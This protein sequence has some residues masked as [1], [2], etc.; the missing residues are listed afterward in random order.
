[1]VVPGTLRSLVVSRNRRLTH[2]LG[3]QEISRLVLTP[4]ARG[5]DSAVDTILSLLVAALAL[6]GL[7]L[8]LAWLLPSPHGSPWAYRIAV[9][10]L[11]AIVTAAALALLLRSGG[12][13]LQPV[14]L[15]AVGVVAWTAAWVVARDRWKVNEWRAAVVPLVAMTGAP[16]IVWMISLAGYGL[17]LPNRDFKNHAYWVAQVSFERS[18]DPTLVLRATPLS[19]PETDKFY[20]L[21]LHTLLGWA[22]PTSDWNTLGVTAG[23]AIICTAVSLP[24]AGVVL[25]RMWVPESQPLWIL[26][27]FA[28]AFFPGM[29]GAFGIGS[30]TI[31]VA[32]ALYSAGL[33]SLWMWLKSPGVGQTVALA[34]TGAGLLLLHI[35]EAWGLLLLAL[36]ALPLVGMERISKLSVRTWAVLGITAA[37]SVIVALATL[38]PILAR[39]TDGFTD[40]QPNDQSVPLAVLRAYSAQ[41]G[42]NIWLGM[43]WMVSTLIGLAAAYRRRLSML[44]ALAL[45]VPMALAVFA[46]T[47][48]VP[49]VLYTMTAPW[50]GSTSRVYLMA[51]PPIALLGCFGLV[52][53]RQ[54]FSERLRGW[55]NQRDAGAWLVLLP[56]LALLVAISASNVPER[57]GSLAAAL[58]G[59]GDTPEVAREIAAALQPGETILNFE[60]DGTAN[61]FAI[62]RLPVLAG[63]GYYDGPVRG[64]SDVEWLASSLMRLDDQPV[65]LALSQLGVRFIAI[66]TTSL[67]W[68]TQ[69]GYD[70]DRLLHQDELS[71]FTVGSDVTVL[72]YEP[73]VQ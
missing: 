8:P 9:A 22:A 24:L 72:E 58:A 30:V 59:G 66:G 27:G 61:L 18:A 68:N 34:I 20:P 47:P 36:V 38:N 23:A 46:S 7:G 39:L 48:G 2:L 55:G 33:A 57:R 53:L 50:Y 69:I 26:T 41:P 49:T 25:A 6:Y 28:L 13:S 11:Y 4:W 14:Y 63:E 65:A 51:G 45:L 52:V 62:D 42:G 40:I 21:G 44:P 73:D 43:I 29:T 1:M 3:S 64:D 17:Y 31:L 60:G 5:G 67:Y 56:G 37:V 19:A 71:V 16:S 15:L 70:I 35:A 12:V 32:G 10:P 54:H